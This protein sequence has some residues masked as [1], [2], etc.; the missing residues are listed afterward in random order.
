MKT[1]ENLSLAVYVVL[2]NLAYEQ[3]SVYLLQ[4]YS[5]SYD[6]KLRHLF[7]YYYASFFFTI[8]NLH[9]CVNFSLHKTGVGFPKNKISIFS[10]LTF[11]T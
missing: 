4:H 8:C 2:Y 6:I 3:L 5:V 11:V 10:F 7:C 1:R 9:I